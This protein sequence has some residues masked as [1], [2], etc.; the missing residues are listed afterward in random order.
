MPRDSIEQLREQIT[1][2]NTPFTHTHTHAITK[3]HGKKKYTHTH[4]GIDYY[5]K[6]SIKL[7][8]ICILFYLYIFRILLLL[9]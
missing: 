1:R 7:F 2:K 3:Q 4:A 8:M 6:R 9:S 5:Y